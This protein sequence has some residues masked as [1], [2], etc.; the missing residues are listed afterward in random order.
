MR[1]E[2]GVQELRHEYDAILVGGNTALVD[3]PSLT[4]R[5]GLQRRKPLVRVILD[6]RLRIRTDSRLATTAKTIPTIVFTQKHDAGLTGPLI[7]KGVDIVELD[8]GG[9]NL[10][11][12]LKVLA[13]REIQSVLVEGGTQVAGE[14]VDSRLVDKIT[15]IAAPIV[16]G[17]H[18]APVAIGGRV[19]STLADALYLE[20]IE[21][22]LLGEDIEITGY[23]RLI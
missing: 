6:N 23:P 20:N 12:V 21:V 4:D 9:R 8:G 22:A 11:T 7:D 17:G 5:S 16:I 14:F 3:D 2:S 18:D 10:E 1:P 19:T 15:F 13:E